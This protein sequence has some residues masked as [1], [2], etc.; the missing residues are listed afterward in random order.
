VIEYLRERHA[1]D[2]RREIELLEAK[3]KE[4]VVLRDQITRLRR[5]KGEL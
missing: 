2:E 3:A 5:E 4:A 1:L